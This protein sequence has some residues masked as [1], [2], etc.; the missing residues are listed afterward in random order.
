MPY[1]RDGIYLTPRR[2]PPEFLGRLFLT[3]FYR[4]GRWFPTWLYLW[5][6]NRLF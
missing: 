3:P 6:L 2:H 4:L 1:S 5:S